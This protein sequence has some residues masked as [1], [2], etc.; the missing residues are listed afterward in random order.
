[1]MDKKQLFYK[2][3]VDGL[4]TESKYLLSK[5]FYDKRGD[6]LFQQIMHSPEYYLTR[7]ELEILS[8]QASCITRTVRKYISDFDVVELGAGDATKSIYLL[9]ECIL[10]KAAYNYYPVDISTNVINLLEKKLPRKL[11]LLNIRGW[12]GEYLNMLEKISQY[13]DKKKLVLFLGG[14]IGNFLPAQARSFLQALHSHLNPGDLLLIGFDLKK[15]PRVILDAY[16]DKEG[17]TR[18]FNLNLLTRINREL[19]AN[20]EIKGFEHYPVYDPATG[21]CKSYLVS[22]YN[23]D[24]NIGT[25]VSIS[26]KKNEIIRMEISQ[27]YSPEETDQIAKDSGFTVVEKFYDRKGWFSDRLWL[28]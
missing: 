13:S 20:F 9:K 8:E 25:E 17:F 10:Q 26:F 6:E 15:H 12:N 4:T 24:V 14:N 21:A 27:K 18:A 3:V 22:L 2:E 5:Y 19:R 1:M 23:Q 7:C 11:P 28:A 16:N